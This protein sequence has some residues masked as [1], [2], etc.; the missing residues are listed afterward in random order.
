M[1]DVETAYLLSIAEDELGVINT[2]GDNGERLIPKDL[3]IVWSSRSDYQ[4]PRK[5]AQVP[6]LN[7]IS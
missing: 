2:L 5:I 4:E 1:G 7:R 3:H 6:N